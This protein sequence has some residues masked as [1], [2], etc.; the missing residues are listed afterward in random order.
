VW[1]VP[2]RDTIFCYYP[3]DGAEFCRLDD[4]IVQAYVLRRK[5]GGRRWAFHVKSGASQPWYS[6]V[7]LKINWC[8][9]GKELKN[10]KT[11]RG[12]LRSRPQNVDFYY[13]PGF[14]WTRRAV[15]FYPY[16]IPSNCIPSVSRY[17]AFPEQGLQTEALGVCASRLISAY[18]RFY[19]EFWQRPNFLV[20]TLKR[21]PWPDLSDDAKTRFD[22][23]VASQVE[24][25]RPL[26]RTMSRFTNSCSRRRFVISRRT[27]EVSHSNLQHCSTKKPS[28]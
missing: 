25:R 18:L 27:G 19:A 11:A 5:E 7:T 26:T 21:V 10:F 13:R 12:K 14:S 9:D 17:M 28:G 8:D 15:R 23:L 2:Y 24:R 3:T 20:D 4:P 6:P 1:E 22:A 16:A